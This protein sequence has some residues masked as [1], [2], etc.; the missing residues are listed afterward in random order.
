MDPKLFFE[1]VVQ[2]R[3]AQKKYFRERTGSSLAA[4]K[5]LEQQVDQAISDR[6]QAGVPKGG[7]Q[8]SFGS[9]PWRVCT[10][11]PAV[12]R[13]SLHTKPRSNRPWLFLASNCNIRDADFANAADLSS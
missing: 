5:K 8:L 3:D 2:M 6:K 1:L 10:E 7:V 9:V 12:I 11:L 4:A 13:D